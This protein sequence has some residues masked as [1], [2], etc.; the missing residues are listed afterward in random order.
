MGN[1]FVYTWSSLYLW[2]SWQNINRIQILSLDYLRCGNNVS[3]FPWKFGNARLTR[4]KFT[5]CELH[6]FIVGQQWRCED[7]LSS[8]CK[9]FAYHAVLS[10]IKTD[11][12]TYKGSPVYLLH[13]IITR[14]NLLN[15]LICLF[16]FDQ[17]DGVCHIEMTKSGRGLLNC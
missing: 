7:Y 15:F 12:N 13:Y 1:L 9:C 16:Q 17:L 2:P 4:Q 11:N 5:I 10:I 8:K 6:G 14:Q 3:Q